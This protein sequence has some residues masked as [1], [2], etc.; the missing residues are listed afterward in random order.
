MPAWPGSTIATFTVSPRIAGWS[1]AE[2]HVYGSA[3]RLVMIR[4]MPPE[5]RSGVELGRQPPEDP[6]GPWRG[7]RVVDLYRLLARKLDRSAAPPRGPLAVSPDATPA[8]LQSG[9]VTPMS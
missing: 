7:A 6:A 8:R 9:A 5:D 1:R 2:S 3:E 4:R